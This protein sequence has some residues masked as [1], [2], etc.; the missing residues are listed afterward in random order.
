[1]TTNVPFLQNQNF[2]DTYFNNPARD[3]IVNGLSQK[4]DHDNSKFQQY[5]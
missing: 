3:N 2:R 1:M 4:G 5:T